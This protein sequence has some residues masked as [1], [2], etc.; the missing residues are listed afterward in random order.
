MSVTYI[1]L[2]CGMPNDHRKNFDLFGRQK[3]RCEYMEY[4]TYDTIRPQFVDY[5]NT[6]FISNMWIMDLVWMATTNDAIILFPFRIL[7]VMQ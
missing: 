3:S 4:A 6:T 5:A 1:D 2:A 7:R